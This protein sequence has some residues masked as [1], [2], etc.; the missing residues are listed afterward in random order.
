[1]FGPPSRSV[2]SLSL[3]V[4]NFSIELDPSKATN[5]LAILNPTHTIWLPNLR[6]CPLFILYYHN[7]T[8]F[9]ISY[10]MLT[11]TYNFKLYLLMLLFLIFLILMSSYLFSTFMNFRYIHT[12]ILHTYLRILLAVK[13]VG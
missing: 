3:T 6:T 11:F 4:H 7:R 9:V 13:T 1:M 8:N 5:T 10:L 2:L 12:T